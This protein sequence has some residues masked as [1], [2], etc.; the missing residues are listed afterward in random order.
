MT[1]S[2]NGFRLRFRPAAVDGPATEAR[3][4]TTARQVTTA[5]HA[6]AAGPTHARAQRPHPTVFNPALLNTGG[7]A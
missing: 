7:H 5:R 3:Q 1:A 6:P 4:T 2:L